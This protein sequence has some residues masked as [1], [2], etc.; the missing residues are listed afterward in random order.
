MEEG[1][2]TETASFEAVPRVGPSATLRDE[3][4]LTA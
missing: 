1:K 2:S 4:A 3:E